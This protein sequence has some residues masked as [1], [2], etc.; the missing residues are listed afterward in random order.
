MFHKSML[1]NN[2]SANIDNTQN[3]QYGNV[4]ENNNQNKGE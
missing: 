3:T 4:Q 1:G 2:K